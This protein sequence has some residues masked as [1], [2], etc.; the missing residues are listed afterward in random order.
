MEARAAHLYLL[1]PN[2]RGRCNLLDVVPY[3]CKKL[4]V[5]NIIT[6][7]YAVSSRVHKYIHQN[8]NKRF[9]IN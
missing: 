1:G 7:V 4:K 2:G 5:E 8:E 9:L 6:P 3:Y